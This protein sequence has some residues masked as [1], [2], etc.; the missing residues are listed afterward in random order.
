M[1]MQNSPPPPPLVYYCLPKAGIYQSEYPRGI[2]TRAIF[3]TWFNVFHYISDCSYLKRIAENPLRKYHFLRQQPHKIY[4]TSDRTNCL[5]RTVFKL[6]LYYFSKFPK[7]KTRKQAVLK[8]RR[9]HVE[10]DD[11]ATI[12]IVHYRSQ[13]RTLEPFQAYR[14]PLLPH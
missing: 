8:T 11:L 2:P 10:T 3:L 13:H 14:G 4:R 12:T 1:S 5:K 9:K 6:E 7:T